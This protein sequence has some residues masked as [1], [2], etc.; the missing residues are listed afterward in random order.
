[1]PEPAPQPSVAIDDVYHVVWS[2]AQR[3]R[4]DATAM[5]GQ[6]GGVKWTRDALTEERLRAHLGDGPA[7]GLCP[8]RAGESTTM[9]ALLDLDSHR[10]ETSWLQMVEVGQR[11]IE[12]LAARGLVAHPWRSRG[13][14][15]LHL[16]LVWDEPQ[17]ARSVRALLAEVLRECSLK[18]GTRGVAAGEVEVFPKQNHV[19]AAGF[20]SMFILPGAGT[21]EPLLAELGLEG[22]GGER[23][24]GLA[25][26]EWTPSSLV[27]VAAPVEALEAPEPEG[28][29]ECGVDAALATRALLAIPNGAES[30][31]D[32]DGW[33]A[34]LCAAKEAG[35][36][37]ETAREWS[38][39][40]PSWA[41]G[42]DEAFDRTWNSIAVGKPD[43][44]RVEVLLRAAERHGFRDHVAADF[45]DLSPARGDGG[46]AGDGAGDGG[47]VPIPQPAYTRDRLGRIEQTSTNALLA[48]RRPSECGCRMAFDVFTDVA[49]F[50]EGDGALRPMRDEDYFTLRVNLEGL[51]FKGAVGPE[52]VKA[53]ARMVVRENA[54]DSA[55]AWVDGLQWDGV[56]RI[57]EFMPRYLKTADTP[58]SRGVGRYLWSALAARALSPGCRVDMTP[59]LV[60]GQ[61]VGK[62]R[63]VA[64]M[65]P[66]PEAFAELD[67]SHRDADLARSVRG[68]LVVELGELRGLRTKDAEAIKSWMSR[69]ADEWTPKYVEFATRLPRRFVTIGTTNENDFLA[70][71][72]GERRWLPIEVGWVDVPAIEQD[73]DQL[74]AEGVAVYR[75]Y[76]VAWQ[77]VEDLA[78]A[79]HEA[80]KSVDP[81]EAKALSWLLAPVPDPEGKIAAGIRRGEQPVPLPRLLGECLGMAAHVQHAGHTRR[82]AAVLRRL[83][84][85][86]RRDPSGKVFSLW[87]AVPGGRF[88]QAVQAGEASD[89]A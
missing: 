6:Q 37:P 40:H 69:T 73:R 87:H 88:G 28:G 13:G 62:T 29:G 75:Q 33:F 89:E 71:A 50:A 16:L 56:P 42:G 4:T 57:D 68:K 23:H 21:S 35:V 3:M 49:L 2:L 78:P 51:G 11:L 74:W 22:Y 27:R 12:A 15:G 60:G 39:A 66:W 19:P 54:H 46:G 77:A 45:E 17:D 79:E 58:Y 10:G 1:M 67:L 9:V 8:I 70:D 14:K 31:L 64:A 5:R 63:A 83:G 44:A 85:E 59:V 20:G 47:P 26:Y 52:M 32:R 18:P 72:T 25:G 34:L 84:F 55:M 43:G 30:G 24:A 53:A 48:L 82:L 38:Q 36:D 80:F 81:W 76:G 7:R 86:K 61:G 41:N 65:A